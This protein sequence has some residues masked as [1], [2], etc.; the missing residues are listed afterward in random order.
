MSRYRNLSIDK[1]IGKVEQRFC[2]GI[3]NISKMYEYV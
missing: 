2:L 1:R 3:L